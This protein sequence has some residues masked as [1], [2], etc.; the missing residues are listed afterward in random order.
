MSETENIRRIIENRKARFEYFILQSLE[1]GIVLVGTEV[2]SLR[3]GKISLTDSYIEIE[4]NEAWLV[5][6]HINEYTEGN[7][8][9]HDP[10]RKRKIL[11]NASEIRKLNS[12][13]NE[14]GLTLIP[15]SLYFKGNKVKVEIALAKGKKS[16][17]KRESIAK[18][19][20][21]RDS[22]I[23]YKIK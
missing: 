12:K 17:D 20:M 6:A 11:L 16:Y 19:D 21:Q 18:K 23:K 1:A 14:K 7:R 15:L 4:N 3:Q 22:E 2:K 5:N 10:K 8:F 13:I 9:N